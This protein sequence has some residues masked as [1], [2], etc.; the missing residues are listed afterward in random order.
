MHAALLV[1][2]IL[3]VILEQCEDWGIQEYRWNLSQLARCCKAWK[4]P[5][6]DRLWG[7]LDGIQPLLHLLPGYT[8]D[9]GI[10]VCTFSSI[11]LSLWLICGLIALR[12]AQH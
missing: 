5:A 11:L 8:F 7:R 12:Q 10:Y 3:E 4:D 2:E 1:D 9:G 6:L